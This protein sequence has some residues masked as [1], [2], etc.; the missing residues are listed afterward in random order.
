MCTLD[1]QTNCISDFSTPTRNIFYPIRP[2]Y[3]HA[4]DSFT[5]WLSWHQIDLEFII[6]ES[7]FLEGGPPF[8]TT[9]KKPHF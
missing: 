8:Q 3:S 1:H 7:P 9:N 4:T 2:S 5:G 6:L